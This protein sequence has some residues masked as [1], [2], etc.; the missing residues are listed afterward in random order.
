MHY[1]HV[2]RDDPSEKFVKQEL[3]ILLVN[4]AQCWLDNRDHPQIS[5]LHLP[6]THL[7]N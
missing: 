2:C 5:L 7:P 3:L 4:Q 1:G 6:V